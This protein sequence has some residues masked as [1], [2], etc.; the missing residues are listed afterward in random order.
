MATDCRAN[1]YVADTDNNRVQKFGDPAAPRCPVLA[2]SFM[3]LGEPSR[4][5]L[6]A[7]AAPSPRTAARPGFEASF[8]SAEGS[9]GMVT[10]PGL[11]LRERR[12]RQRGSFTLKPVG[13]RSRRSG[14]PIARFSRGAWYALFDVDADL[15]T[16]TGSATGTVLATSKNK[17]A[18]QICLGFK[19]TARVMAGLP[20]SGKFRT[21]GGTRDGARLNAGGQL[22]AAGRRG[23][24]LDD[25]RHQQRQAAKSKAAAEAVP[26]GQEGLPVALKHAGR[27]FAIPEMAAVRC[28]AGTRPGLR[29]TG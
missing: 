10:R 14:L 3:P 12:G 17:R 23:P 5:A 6:G 2:K 24:P 20:L 11:R 4:A 16:W 28:W 18:G 29:M 22:H 8:S 13:R 26:P 15:R 27:A 9:S 1:V 25:P 21:L 7:E 19:L